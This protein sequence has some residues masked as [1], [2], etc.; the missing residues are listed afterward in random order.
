MA[1]NHWI[2]CKRDTHISVTQDIVTENLTGRAVVVTVIAR[3]NIDRARR[4]LRPTTSLETF[5]Q[6]VRNS[7]VRRVLFLESSR[8]G[9]SLTLSAAQSK[10]HSSAS[11][12]VMPLFTIT[13]VILGAPTHLL[14]QQLDTIRNRT[15]YYCTWYGLANCEGG[16]EG[17]RLHSIQDRRERERKRE[18]EIL[19]YFLR[20]LI[21]KYIGE[22]LSRLDART[23][24]STIAICRHDGWTEKKAVYFLLRLIFE[25]SSVPL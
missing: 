7:F 9:R 3:S 13:C 19:L 12:R 20:R 18:R 6:C 22:F 11:R 8:A 14:D 1:T 24:I 16:F 5:I 23:I 21:G 25:R 4:Y 2:L 10:L 17:V 15:T